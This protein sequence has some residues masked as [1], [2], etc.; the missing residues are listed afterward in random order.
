MDKKPGERI[1]DLQCGG[2]GVIQ[3]PA[4][5]CFGVDAV[6]LANFAA[7]CPQ[8][9]VMDLCPGS[10]VIPILLCAKHPQVQVTGLEIAPE[11]ADRARRSVAMNGLAHRIRIDDGDVTTVRAQYAHALFD[12]VTVNP[13]YMP[14]TSGVKNQASA[15]TVA[16][17]EVACTLADVVAAAAFLLKPGGRLYM[18]HRPHRLAEIFCALRRKRLEPKTLQL[19]QSGPAHVPSLVLIEAVDQGRPQLQVLPTKFLDVKEDT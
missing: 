16:R 1:D 14:A 17:H 6:C 5:F 7:L 9:H 12:A 13:P 15:K 11:V 2:F 8:D 4:G 19:V 10:G 18:V 3:D